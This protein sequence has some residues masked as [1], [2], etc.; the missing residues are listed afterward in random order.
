MAR[1]MMS[2]AG[3]DVCGRR[4]VS[5]DCVMASTPVEVSEL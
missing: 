4:I 2:K 1:A 3:D 5:I